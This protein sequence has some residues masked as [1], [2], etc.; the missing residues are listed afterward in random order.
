MKKLICL[1]LLAAM[2][3]G[4]TVQGETTHTT[5]PSE[6]TQPQETTRATEP[7]E[8]TGPEETT[9]PQETGSGAIGLIGDLPELEPIE[10]RPGTGD[11]EIPP[12]P[13]QPVYTQ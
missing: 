1:V 12:Q 8:S 3:C 11:V 7:E 9:Q 5:V 10:S 6:S 13:T 4:C 2:L